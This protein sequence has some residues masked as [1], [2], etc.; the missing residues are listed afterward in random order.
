V[1]HLR[2]G[3]DIIRGVQ[4]AVQ[5]V[6]A[7]FVRKAKTDEQRVIELDVKILS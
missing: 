3:V 4:I 5:D 2:Y 6:V 7:S 1:Q